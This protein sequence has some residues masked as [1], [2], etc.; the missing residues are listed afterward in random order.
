MPAGNKPGNNQCAKRY[1]QIQFN[2]VFHMQEQKK[3]SMRPV[4]GQSIFDIILM[5]DLWCRNNHWC[6]CPSSWL[7]L[8]SDSSCIKSVVKEDEKLIRFKAKYLIETTA[9]QKRA[10]ITD[11]DTNGAYG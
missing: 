11:S 2:H 1:I 6:Y 7:I 5:M 4:P 9:V 10:F 8:L 3:P